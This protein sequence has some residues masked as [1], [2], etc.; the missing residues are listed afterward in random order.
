MKEI[1]KRATLRKRMQ[2]VLYRAL[3]KKLVSSVQFGKKHAPLAKRTLFSL[4]SSASLN[5][6]E[7]EVSNMINLLQVL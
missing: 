7:V 5:I 3:L 6:R 4:K 1:T 2:V